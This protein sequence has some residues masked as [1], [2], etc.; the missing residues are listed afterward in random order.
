MRARKLLSWLVLAV[1]VTSC[2]GGAGVEVAAPAP[3]QFAAADYAGLVQDLYVAY[4]GRPADSAGLAFWSGALT[5]AG[6]P[7]DLASL[8]AAYGTNPGVKTVIDSFGASPESLVLYDT[9]NVAIVSGIYLNLF[10]RNPEEAGFAFWVDA[11]NSKRM[12]PMQAA[13]TIAAGAVGSDS[14][15]VLAKTGASIQ[16][17]SSLTTREQASTYSGTTIALAMRIALV[18]VGSSSDVS[19][20]GRSLIHTLASYSCQA[21]PGECTP[22]FT[23][24]IS[25][26]VTGLTRGTLLLNNAGTETIAVSSNGNFL[27]AK[28]AAEGN[29][30]NVTVVGEPSGLNCVVAN[31][32]GTIVHDTTGGSNVN[33]ACSEGASAFTRFNLGITVSGLSPGNSVTFVNNG[34]DTLTVSEDGLFVFPKAYVTTAVYSGRV[35][36]YEVAVKTQPVNQ[37]CTVNN[38][39]G[40]QTGANNFVNLLVSCQ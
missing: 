21:F 26:T 1:A 11:L 4:F 25:G 18:A 34:L 17:T 15:S 19:A 36:G 37:S 23:A 13:I 6:A 7:T 35:G 24:S 5:A 3:R 31:G 28:Q 14:Q 10:N 30:F 40:A 20:A 32:I 12:T 39:S 27:F 29:A 38:G 16:F 8:V 33:V 9:G 22:G 2:G